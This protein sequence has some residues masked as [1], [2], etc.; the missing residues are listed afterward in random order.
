MAITE[1]SFTADEIQSALAA[2]PALLD[3][4]K[5]AA[6]KS[7]I[8]VYS[9][10]E[11]DT[12]VQGVKQDAVNETTSTLYSQLDKD[13]AALTGSAKGNEKT[14]DFIKRVIDEQKTERTRLAGEVQTLNE[15]IKTGGDTTL[16]TRYEALE[17][18]HKNLN[19]VV[20]PQLNQSLIQTKIGTI[21]SE[22]KA[23]L[24]FNEAYSQDVID[25][26]MSTATQK[27]MAAAK[28]NGDQILFQDAEGKP[29]MNGINVAD[30]KSVFTN[31]LPA[32]AL[33]V[34]RTAEGADTRAPV[35]TTSFKNADGQPIAI[36]SD[37]KT[38]VQLHEYL[39]G[40]GLASTSKEFMEI[41]TQYA[42][43]PTM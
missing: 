40:Q 18:A 15:Q 24:A 22:A 34:G 1:N 23:G 6:P 5:E 36:S 4:L 21:I 37:I 19:D 8:F 16:K 27:M 30:P 17:L 10:P 14:Y 2:N 29:F 13:V 3:V 38:K 9:K 20:I 35:T 7:N 32:A 33:T 12:Y 11:F 42:A 26:L 43:L 28:V 39:I 41:D 31:F 25:V